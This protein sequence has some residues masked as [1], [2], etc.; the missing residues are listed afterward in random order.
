MDDAIYRV[1]KIIFE[2]QADIAVKWALT[3]LATAGAGIFTWL[4][5]RRV[6]QEE[7]KHRETHTLNLFEALSQSNPHLQLAVA[8][9]LVERLRRLIDA[10]KKTTM[11]VS[12]QASIEHALHSMLKSDK[13][14]VIGSEA[15]GEANISP[16]LTKFVAE[17]LVMLNDAQP[18]SAGRPPDVDG[19]EGRR[20]YLKPPKHRASP[21]RRF[22]WQKV[23]IVEAWLPGVDARGVDFF[24]AHLIDCG[25][26][27]ARLNKA[28]FY[29]AELRGTKL[30][31]ADLSGA[32]L[33]DA[34]LDNVDLREAKLVG[35]D[36]SVARN[37]D[38]ARWSRATYSKTTK[39]PEGFNPRDHEMV[40]INDASI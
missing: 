20:H 10:K 37:W 3:L 21:L 19:P 7:E 13:P 5:R 15:D 33:Y 26:R 22:D 31:G 16:Q 30:S 32:N 34:N 29:Q 40:L 2:E 1:V 9:V 12:E 36:L 14:A 17:H 24:Q 28:V 25:L 35:V 23:K 18:L 6:Q 11:D 27:Y 39:F 4:G 38:K 8:S